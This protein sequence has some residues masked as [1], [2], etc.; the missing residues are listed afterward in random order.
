MPR[1]ISQLEAATDVTASDL[2][3]VIDIEDTGMA[4]S[5]TNKRATAQLM[6][7]ELGKLTNITATGS[8]TA[9]TLANR[10]ADVVNVKD[11]GAVGDGVADDSAAFDAAIAS[12]TLGPVFVPK[13]DYNA[14]FKN[15]QERGV[16]SLSDGASDNVWLLSRKITGNQ[17]I[18][19]GTF[20]GFSPT[21]YMQDLEEDCE[22]IGSEFMIAS[23]VR[24]RFLGGTN[25][26]GG[27]TAFL[28]QMQKLGATAP[29]NQ[30]RNYVSSAAFI[31]VSSDDGGT[32]TLSNSTAKGGHFAGSWA[33]Y[34]RPEGKNL[35]NV[36]GGEINIFGESGASTRYQSG[37][38]IAC[39]YA[40]RGTESDAALSIS[41][42]S[43]ATAH[44]GYGAGI[45]FS[46]TNGQHP[47]S[48]TSTIILAKNGPNNISSPPSVFRG[49]DFSQ[50]NI[51]DAILK[52]AL[53][54]V[55]ENR[56]T[57]G[58]DSAGFSVINLAGATTDA[59]YVLRTKG[60]GAFQLQGETG[61]NYFLVSSTTVRN[62]GS[63]YT[64]NHDVSTI[65]WT[66]GSGSPDGVVTAN[67]GSLYSRSD[68]GAG[69]SLYVK[70]SGT[71]NIGWVA[72]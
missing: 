6:A 33:V 5:G 26:H 22:V 64:L 47:F 38:S 35:L 29:D 13:G 23:R 72:K 31:T 51:T 60:A 46:S 25:T 18:G 17:N 69:T 8:N 10:F 62:H 27:R 56:M 14:G 50:Y 70:E 34:L 43:N 15:W 40:Q 55:K 63:T 42:I 7:N 65:R 3:Q 20:S 71:G 30:N 12:P 57:L 45:L 39:A 11:F 58:A 59:S 37:L 24:H 9:R 54:E 4:V 61:S 1:K 68:G 48:S 41:G 49:I 2:I 52:G 36:C 67:V 53:F 16:I 44:V 32:D 28:S 66:T 21:A 19:S